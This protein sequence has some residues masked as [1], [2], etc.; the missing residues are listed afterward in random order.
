MKKKTLT[1]K[2]QIQKLEK[3]ISKFGD[4]DKSRTQKIEE[5]RKNL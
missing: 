5:L 3:S 2:Q 1:I 4:Y